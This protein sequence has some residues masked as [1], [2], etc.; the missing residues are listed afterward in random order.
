MTKK[1]I[2]HMQDGMN[3]FQKLYKWKYVKGQKEHGGNLYQ[4]SI[5]QL[6]TEAK[7][8][9]A[10][11]WAYL[12]TATEQIQALAEDWRKRADIDILGNAFTFRLCADELEELIYA[13]KTKSPNPKA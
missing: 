2:K 1:Q 12:D 13:D 9:T 10:D 11:L 3:R 4:M 7:H 6:L 8:E 5:W